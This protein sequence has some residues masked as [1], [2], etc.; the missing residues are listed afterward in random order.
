MTDNPN[1]NGNGYH[2]F[3]I[4]AE[5]APDVEKWPSRF[6]V[7]VRRSGLAKLIIKELLHYGPRNKDV[8]LSRPCLYGV[9]SGPV[10]GFMPRDQH[11]VGCLRCTTEFPDFVRVSH[12]PERRKLGDSFFDF[13]VVD[14]VTYEAESGLIPVKGAGYRGKFGGEGW[15]GMWTDMSEIVR[16]TR[17]G[18]H[19][20]EFI[21]TVVDIG[22]RPNFLMFDE[23]GRSVGRTPHVFQ[24]PLPLLFDVLPKSAASERTWRITARAATELGTLAVIPIGAVLQYNLE[25]DHVA[26]LVRPGEKDALPVLEKAPRLIE[27]DGWEEG[28]YR[29][30]HTAFPES[31]VALR[32]PFTSGQELLKFAR[33]G[34]RVFHLTADYHGRDPKG[35]FVLD[36]IRRA[37]KAFVEA[38]IRQ[39]VTLLGSG[40]I[41]HAEHV[42][43]AILCGLDAVA[44]DTAA[45]VA[46]QARFHGECRDRE[47]SRFSLPRKL[48]LAWGAQRLVNLAASWR[49]QLLE[50][51][52]A[53]GLREVRRL[54]GEMGR[55][56]FMEDLERE[57]FAGVNGYEPGR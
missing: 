4:V 23:E 42:P 43:K 48:T 26:P 12:N 39:E 27:M 36:L 28:L 53:M 30:I 24:I 9:F 18:I 55:A 51:M 31:L 41:I 2:R 57:A 10:G 21:S 38:G 8:I 5:R 3:H 50:I 19:G 45:L 54:R 49:D 25:S 6:N 17:D 35:A 22:A 32:I 13:R 33:K 37:H 20:R 29:A 46:L 11:C 47:T 15:D 40:G 7:R 34:I 1:N 52:G 14:S 56:M 44:L 16:P